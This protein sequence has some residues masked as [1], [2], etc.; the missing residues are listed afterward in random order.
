MF[1]RA[2]ESAVHLIKKVLWDTKRTPVSRMC[3]KTN[4]LGVSY[5]AASYETIQGTTSSRT[6][7]PL[8]NNELTRGHCRSPKVW[9]GTK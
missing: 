2:D 6:D 1:T 8:S 7:P 5:N 4:Q 3:N 9:S